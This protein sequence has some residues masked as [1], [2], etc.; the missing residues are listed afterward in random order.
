[1]PVFTDKDKEA[2]DI[3]VGK[4]RG[5]DGNRAVRYDELDA[6]AAKLAQAAT[7]VSVD[8]AVYGPPPVVAILSSERIL[9]ANNAW[10]DVA[11][12][13]VPR[14]AGVPVE[15][16]AFM[17]LRAANT[18]GSGTLEVGFFRGGTAIQRMTAETPYL[19]GMLPVAMG[20]IDNNATGDRVTYTLK[21]KK[22]APNTTGG[23]DNNV[24]IS[25]V[26]FIA[27]Q[28]GRSK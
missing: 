18:T 25:K 22:A 2:L 15:V 3:L 27:R 14:V 11:S 6:L 24:R 20:W 8:S 26:M 12:I 16:Y 23:A 1:M 17:Q 21:C 10:S 4:R 5:P 7:G 19:G 9:N 28:A 13:V